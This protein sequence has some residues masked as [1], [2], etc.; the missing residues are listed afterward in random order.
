MS[1][2]TLGITLLG[3]VVVAALVYM[4]AFTEPMPIVTDTEDMTAEE[5]SQPQ[6]K[7]DI[8]AVCNGALAYMSFPDAVAAEVFVAECKEGKHPEVIAEW[9]AQK[10][11]RSD[12]AP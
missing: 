4:F 6:G 7:L 10:G 9:R 3:I 1:S 2:K 11:I 5:T 8:N 12:A